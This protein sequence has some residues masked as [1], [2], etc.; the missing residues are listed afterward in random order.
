ML[1]EHGVLLPG[2]RLV[3]HVPSTHTVNPRLSETQVAVALNLTLTLT[4]A[5]T[6]L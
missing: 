4:L 1:D 6:L 3:L 5:L 2:L